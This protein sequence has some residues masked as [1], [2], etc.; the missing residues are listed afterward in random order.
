L[1]AIDGVDTIANLNRQARKRI[2]IMPGSGVS[3]E[4]VSELISKTGVTEIH[5]SAVSFRESEMTWRNMS[6]SGMGNAQN[7][8]FVVRTVHPN[9]ILNIRMLGNNSF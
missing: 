3:E 6:I 8:E 9:K 1:R 2:G 7:S 5:F 4:N